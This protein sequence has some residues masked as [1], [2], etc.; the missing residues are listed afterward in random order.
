MITSI[1]FWNLYYRKDWCYTKSIFVCMSTLKLHSLCA[2]NNSCAYSFFFCMFLIDEE[3][4]SEKIPVN[5]TLLQLSSNNL[6][7]KKIMLLQLHAMMFGAYNPLDTS[8]FLLLL[9]LVDVLYNDKLYREFSVVA[10][11]VYLAHIQSF[12]SYKNYQNI[13][14]YSY[15]SATFH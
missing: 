9:V 2:W 14:Y 13:E 1:Y 3:Y 8:F 7:L 4:Y 5:T 12:H 10:T 15:K 6:F 11:T